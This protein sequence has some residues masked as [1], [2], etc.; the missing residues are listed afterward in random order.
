MDSEFVLTQGAGHKL[1]TAIKRNGANIGDV[2]WLSAGENFKSVMM[3]ARGEAELAV[4]PRI[5]PQ[6]QSPL[7]SIIRVDRK[8]RPVYPDWM[9]RVMYPK[10]EAV[11]PAEYDLVKVELWLHD[12]QKNLGLVKGLD[13]YEHLKNNRMLNSCLGLRDGEEI[14]KKGVAVFRKFFGGQA[15]FLWASVMLSRCGY[16]YV[17]YLIGSGGAV[18]LRWD[19]LEDDWRRYSPA[20]RFAS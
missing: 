11:G 14:K 1:E 7:D 2:E 10:L 6:A 5:A 12:G 17:P 20:A 9:K 18:L 16:L 3:L 4:K 15:I 8:V 13:I 19:W